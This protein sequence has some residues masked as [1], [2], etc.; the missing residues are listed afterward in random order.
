MKLRRAFFIIFTIVALMPSLSVLAFERE[1]W[2]AV[3]SANFYLVGNAEPKDMQ[4]VAA[5]LEQFRAAFTQLFGRMNFNS[6]ISTTVVVFKN[7]ASLAR[8]K[9]QTETGATKDWVKGFFLGG[10]DVNYIALS[11]EGARDGDYSTIFHEYVHFL[12]DNTLGKTNV[13]PWF[14]EGL[15]EYYEQF[16]IENDRKVT[17][18][19]I[20]NA[21]LK[22]LQKEGFLPF[23]QFFAID[24]YT[25]NRQSKERVVAFYAQAWALTHFLMHAGKSAQSENFHR[26]A[27]QII[28]GKAV[29]EAFREV[30]RTDFQTLEKELAGYIRQKSLPVSTVNLEK[31]VYSPTEFNFV[32]LTAAEAKAF[33]GDL[34][35]QSG[36][37]AEAEKLLREAL[38]ANPELGFAN[39]SLGLLKIKEKNYAEAKIYLEKAVRADEKNYFAHYAYAFLL[40]REGVTDFGFIVGYNG[41]AAEKI[42]ESLGRAIALNPGFAESYQLFAF[43]NFV[44]NENLDEGLEMIGRALQIAPGNQLYNL[45]RAELLMRK[46]DFSAARELAEKIF[47][48]ASE[49]QFKFYAQSTLLQI[50]AWEAQLRA[51]EESRKRPK[52]NAAVTDKPLSEEEIRKLNERAMLESLNQAL[53]RPRTGEKRILGFLSNVECAEKS[54][55]YTVKSENQIFRFESRSVDEIALTSFEAES[56]NSRFGC[57][58]LQ[59]EKFAVLTFKPSANANSKITGD[60]TAIEFVPKS[61]VFLDL[62]QIKDR[63]EF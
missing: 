36:R 12:V 21:H 63:R 57:G 50:N 5:R 3:R 42:R 53:R 40:S 10:K 59:T 46:Q 56:V 17:L 61:F 24:Y 33:E 28:K 18:G 20:N 15:A 41:A 25:L 62:S 37:L 60:V 1:E 23:E 16:Q 51:I 14:N 13:P 9:P 55:I 31:Q 44:R 32:A 22:H 47:R 43:V 35:N 26:F 11:A 8:F 29:S 34:L 49:E 38:D 48:T 54:V 6:P 4:T 30:F 7:E 52:Q 19:K 2:R 45:R 27:D 58:L 39:T